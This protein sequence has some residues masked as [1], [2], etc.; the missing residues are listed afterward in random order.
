MGALTVEQ[1]L[2]ELLGVSLGGDVC[3]C[4]WCC[5]IDKVEREY[6]PNLEFVITDAARTVVALRAEGH[7]VLIHC[8]AAQSRTPTVGVA[9]A[10]IS[11]VDLDTA[12]K[13]VTSALPDARLI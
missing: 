7:G 8:V 10:M 4:P 2:A 6:N 5:L 9:Y 11:G 13:G 3:R 1:A 12:T